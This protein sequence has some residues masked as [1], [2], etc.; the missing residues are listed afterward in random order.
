MICT[1]VDI[2]AD[3]PKPK[4]AKMAQP[5]T[6]EVVFVEIGT[7]D[8]ALANAVASMVTTVNAKLA[9]DTKAQPT[10]V[11]ILPWY[12]TPSGGDQYLFCTVIGEVAP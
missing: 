4:G 2:Q 1:A 11:R 8:N 5:K 3:R 12:S 6:I 10:P 9:L 7:E